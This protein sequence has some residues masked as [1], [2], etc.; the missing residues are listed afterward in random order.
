MKLTLGIKGGFH[1]R[2]DQETLGPLS[3]QQSQV[4]WIEKVPS[5]VKFH[6]GVSE[7]PKEGKRDEG[8][9]EIHSL[10]SQEFEIGHFQEQ[11]ETIEL[12]LELQED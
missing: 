10:I 8:V 9:E 7:E 3:L 11:L 4:D 6:T 1:I 5:A 2:L 12:T